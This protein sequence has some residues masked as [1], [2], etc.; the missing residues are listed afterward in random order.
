MFFGGGGGGMGGGGMGGSGGFRWQAYE[1]PVAQGKVGEDIHARFRYKTALV[2]MTTLHAAWMCFTTIDHF[3]MDCFMDDHTDQS[4]LRKER[5]MHVLLEST[6]VQNF[7][8]YLDSGRLVMR[9]GA[10]GK[11][12]SLMQSG[13]CSGSKGSVRLCHQQCDCASIG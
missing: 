12:R 13:K 7:K 6:A 8:R 11:L 10:D 2:T 9:I 4:T 1:D 3:S 5:M